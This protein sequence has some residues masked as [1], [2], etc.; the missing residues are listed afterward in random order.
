MAGE[1]TTWRELRR[2]MLHDFAAD[3]SF[4]RI[5]QYTISAAGT[6]GSRTLMY[7]SLTEFKEMLKFV[8]DMVMNEEGPDYIGRTYARDGGRG[9]R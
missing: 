3:P 7:R 2:Q 9:G 8:D 1:F 6:G 4:R 5:S